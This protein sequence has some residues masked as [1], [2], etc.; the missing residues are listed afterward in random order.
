M[1]V[2]VVA[3][4]S[5]SHALA[6]LASPFYHLLANTHFK[7][8]WKTALIFPSQSGRDCTRHNMNRTSVQSTPHAPH[9][10]PIYMDF[11]TQALLSGNLPRSEESNETAQES[12]ASIARDN[13][14]TFWSG[15]LQGNS[16]LHAENESIP[17]MEVDLPMTSSVSTTSLDFFPTVERF[18][19]DLDTDFASVSQP[20]DFVN[21]I[22]M[23]WSTDL[24]DMLEVPET[25]G[26]SVGR[27]LE[28]RST[29]SATAS[30]PAQ[31]VNWARPTQR[32][33]GTQARE[34]TA[35][36]TTAPSA[37]AGNKEHRAG[38]QGLRASA[39]LIQ[40]EAQPTVRSLG[41]HM[42]ALSMY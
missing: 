19:M 18:Q 6:L 35:V 25:R 39:T 32:A 3:I 36:P 11:L 23:S 27:A 38:L 10:P 5:I 2:F 9:A 7:T 34:T 1:A 4:P 31:D 12:L 20:A 37:A 29:R 15:L 22:S 30:R 26:V 13:Y 21:D 41:S 28:Q 40:N 33:G 24:T 16:A 14:S 17:Y 42:R 8:N